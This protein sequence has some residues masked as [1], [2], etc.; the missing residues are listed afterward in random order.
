MCRLS[1]VWKESFLCLPF[2]RML[3]KCC[4]NNCF[5]TQG[6]SGFLSKEQ[7]IRGLLSKWNWSIKSISINEGMV[8]KSVGRGG[9]EEKVLGREENRLGPSMSNTCT[10]DLSWVVYKPRQFD[11][12]EV[13]CDIMRETTWTVVVL[14]VCACCNIRLMD[15]DEPFLIYQH[16]LSPM[17]V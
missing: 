6:I 16:F 10:P 7:E 3:L 12:P 2:W 14:K 15:N 17:S 11:S 1:I 8:E 9:M 5:S 4:P 13:N